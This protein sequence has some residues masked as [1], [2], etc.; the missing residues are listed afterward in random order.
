MR[1]LLIC[2][3]VVIVVVV[4]GWLLWQELAYDLRTPLPKVL[5]E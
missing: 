2:V 3:I 4:V 1:R 5:P